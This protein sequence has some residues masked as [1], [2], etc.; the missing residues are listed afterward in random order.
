MIFELC[1]GLDL[2]RRKDINV[3]YP[4]HC[5]APAN[6]L[7]HSGVHV[8]VELTTFT[9]FDCCNVLS[10]FG[11]YYYRGIRANYNFLRIISLNQIINSSTNSLHL[12]IHTIFLT[13]PLRIGI[14]LRSQNISCIH[15]STTTQSQFFCRY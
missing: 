6:K 1:R 3:S 11:T 5:L 12:R 2:F 9:I 10:E 7:L 13:T 8:S 14:N 15:T 4:C